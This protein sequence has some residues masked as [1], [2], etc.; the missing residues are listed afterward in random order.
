MDRKT[1]LITGASSGI[2]LECARQF[3]SKN[4]NVISFDLNI[5]PIKLVESYIVDIRNE[6]ANIMHDRI[7]KVLKNINNK[8]E[9]HGFRM[10]KKK[11]ATHVLFDIEET[12]N[13]K[14]SKKEITQML[15]NEFKDEEEKYLFVFTIDKPFI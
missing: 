11:D 15:E 9:I 13:K 5:C 3:L 4:W 7:L 14:L 12:Y 8:I 2:G 1:V 6:K 10:V